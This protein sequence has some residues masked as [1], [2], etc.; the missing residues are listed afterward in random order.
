MNVF[1]VGKTAVD[2]LLLKPYL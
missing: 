1:F 2:C